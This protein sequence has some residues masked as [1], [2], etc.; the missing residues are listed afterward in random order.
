MSINNRTPLLE[1]KQSNDE[2]IIDT[3]TSSYQQLILNIPTIDNTNLSQNDQLQSQNTNTLPLF[4]Q[5]KTLDS[6]FVP[7]EQIHNKDNT[8]KGNHINTFQSYFIVQD[9]LLY[10]LEYDE[11]CV[12]E[13]CGEDYVHLTVS[14]RYFKA[15]E[16][17][18]YEVFSKNFDK[19]IEHKKTLMKEA[20]MDKKYELKYYKNSK[21][22]KKLFKKK[23]VSN[24]LLNVYD[25][26]SLR[27]IKEIKLN[28]KL[29]FYFREFG[30]QM[31]QNYATIFGWN[32]AFTFKVD[33]S[34]TQSNSEEEEE[35]KEKEKSEE[36]EEHKKDEQSQ[37]DLDCNLI[38]IQGNQLLIFNKYCKTHESEVFHLGDSI[39]L[40]RN[41]ILTQK[42]L[43]PLCNRNPFLTYCFP[44]CFLIYDDRDQSTLIYDFYK[45]D[46][47]PQK[48]TTMIPNIEKKHIASKVKHQD[49]LQFIDKTDKN[50]YL[51][52]DSQIVNGKDFDQNLKNSYFSTDSEA[53]NMLNSVITTGN[54][55]KYDDTKNKYFVTDQQNCRFF[56]FNKKYHLIDFSNNQFLLYRFDQLQ[57]EIYEENSYNDDVYFIHNNSNFCLISY[58]DTEDDMQKLKNFYIGDPIPIYESTN[59][60]FIKD[61]LSDSAENEQ[62]RKRLLNSKNT[63][64]SKNEFQIKI[65]N[66]FYDQQ[67]LSQFNKFQ[68][69]KKQELKQEELDLPKNKFT[70]D[71][72]FKRVVYDNF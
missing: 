61:Y 35:N 29:S 7:F 64:E 30:F 45:N 2:V 11:N 13:I 69:K 9:N 28:L 37:E 17:F 10:V 27:L 21:M 39:Y 1:K 68:Y 12:K 22:M 40:L 32:C 8:I 19:I 6:N 24:F 67:V 65:Q 72:K 36:D 49:Y 25:L 16:K 58:I 41:G 33:L 54:R 23:G 42:L 44:N 52:N 62:S 46:F 48:I 14:Q 70:I 4:E 15:W 51:I 63:Q 60:S 55:F 47:V 59:I 38:S 31:S 43:N 71:Q 56:Y 50:L 20:L 66:Q 57:E 5:Y 3:S 53:Y 34:E 26:P 18:S